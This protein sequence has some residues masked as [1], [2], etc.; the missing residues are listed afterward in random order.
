MTRFSNSTMGEAPRGAKGRRRRFAVAATACAVVAGAVTVGG[1]S[2]ANA[3]D[4]DKPNIN[5]EYAFTFV[6]QSSGLANMC[7]KDPNSSAEPACLDVGAGEE[8]FGNFFT[9]IPDPASPQLIP[10]VVDA[11]GQSFQGNPSA[12][13]GAGSVVF[14]FCF[15]GSSVFEC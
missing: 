13:T 7:V 9:T 4:A 14:K 8:K 10:T 12:G 11:A 3:Q 2:M 1:I 5:I 6:N 15:D